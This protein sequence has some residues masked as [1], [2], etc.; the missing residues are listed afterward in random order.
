MFRNYFGSIW[1]SIDPDASDRE[2][3]EFASIT[4]TVKETIVAETAP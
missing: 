3:Q 4:S 2:P 1:K